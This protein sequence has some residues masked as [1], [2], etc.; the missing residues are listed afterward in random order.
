MDYSRLSRLPWIRT[1]LVLGAIALAA[2]LLAALAVAA[3]FNINTDDRS[4]AEWDAQGIAPYQTDPAESAVLTPTVSPTDDIVTTWVASG[5]GQ[6]GVP[7]LFF[8]LQT[9]QPRA[10]ATLSH[11]A[12]ALID[13]DRNGL[14]NERRDRWAVY[15]ASGFPS[16]EM[17]LYTGDVVLGLS[18]SIVLPQL[19]GQRVAQDVEWA[20]PIADLP[21]E[22]VGAPELDPV[23][24]RNDV[25]IRFATMVYSP[26]I[27]TFTL[28]DVTEPPLGWNIALGEPISATLHIRRA[29][30]P[31][32]VL[33]SWNPTAQSESYALLRSSDP[34]TGFISSAITPTLVSPV[35]GVFTPTLLYTDTGVLTPTIA[36]LFYQVQGTFSATATVDPSNLVGL[37]NFPLLPGD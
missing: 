11:V 20:V 36:T 23:D 17:L 4:V 13:C 24:C 19:L 6:S 29:I 14:D 5:V 15:H 22:G 8:R 16:D 9:A 12:V 21:E 35:P 18:S 1:G 27:G 25:D 32:D 37:A 33:L 28:L 10:L 3:Q 30:S 34:Y 31:T 7:S 2:G 26:T